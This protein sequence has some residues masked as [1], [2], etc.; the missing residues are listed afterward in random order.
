[1]I[2]VIFEPTLNISELE[3]LRLEVHATRFLR[4]D[5]DAIFDSL[6]LDTVGNLLVGDARRGRSLH[7]PVLRVDTTN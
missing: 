6:L 3:R 2:F 1:V 4:T 7:A 5:F